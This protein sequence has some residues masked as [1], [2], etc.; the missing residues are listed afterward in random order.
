[1]AR[2]GRQGGGAAPREVAPVRRL[3]GAF[4]LDPRGH[5]PKYR[6]IA[7]GVVGALKSGALRKGDRLPSIN[8][9][10][11]THGLS[12]D[13]VVKAY[14][15][16]EEMRYLSAIHG[17]GFFLR[18]DA[19]DPRLRVFVL[20]DTLNAFKENVFAGLNDTASRRADVDV[21]FHHFNP[22]LFRRLLLE[23]RGKYDRYVVMPFPAREVGEALAALEAERLL[24]LDIHACVPSRRTP[25]IVQNFDVQLIQALEAGRE[26]LRRYR[27]FILVF[28]PGNHD[29]VEIQDAFLR[30]GRRAGLETRIVPRLTEHMVET[31]SAYLVLDDKDL[32]SLVKHC[33]ATGHR[34]GED[35]GVLSY[36]DTPLKEVVAGGISV[37]SIDFYGLGVRA[38]QHVL[39]PGL[40]RETVPTRL[41]L[42]SSL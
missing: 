2:A 7:D 36:N 17:K 25:W 39:E 16:L 10:C 22:G 42:R 8:E 18:T 21:C 30:F 40:V 13:T 1:V 41:V 37:V 20:F 32:V 9:A 33:N 6:Q 19:A 5:T 3:A 15:L 12:R 29:P 24:V 27:R 28:P 31:E 38:G 4:R 26:R 34:L 11:S 35:V 14:H 23:A